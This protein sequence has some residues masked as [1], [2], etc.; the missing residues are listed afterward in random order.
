MK[1]NGQ[2]I[3]HNQMETAVLGSGF[4]LL[5]SAWLLIVGRDS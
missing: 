4:I 1:L 3:T 5:S 2:E